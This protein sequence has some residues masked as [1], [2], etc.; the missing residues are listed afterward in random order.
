MLLDE[1]R[2]IKSEKRDLRNFGLV[3]GGVFFVL[4]CV[5]LWYQRPSNP[6]FLA[7][8]AALIAGGLVV[9]GVLKPLQRAW[10]A[11]AVV[12]GFIMTR[13][14]LSL[15][16]YLV[17]T[18]IGMAAR[19]VGKD[20]LERRI[21]KSSESYWHMREASGEDHGEDDGEEQKF[22]ERQF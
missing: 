16:F 11:L 20:F 1:I 17:V 5:L 15:L 14:I 10:M 9:P 13:V 18:P 4:G 6:Y 22:Y 7:I 21:D 12:L 3:V 19:L 2:N 8:G